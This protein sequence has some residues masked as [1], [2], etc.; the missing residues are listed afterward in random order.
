MRGSTSGSG[1]TETLETTVE[2]RPAE[3]AEAGVEGEAA[4]GEEAAGQ[5]F[6]L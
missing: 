1:A 4:A 2:G 6:E 3:A 5:E